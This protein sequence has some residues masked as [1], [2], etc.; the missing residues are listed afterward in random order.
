MRQG[1]ACEEDPV[2]APGA[3]AATNAISDVYAM[4]GTPLMAIAGGPPL[5]GVPSPPLLQ[6]GGFG[7]WGG[8]FP[9][10]EGPKKIAR[11]GGFQ[12]FS[13]SESGPVIPPVCEQM[14][15]RD[16]W[17]ADQHPRPGPRRCWASSG[18]THLVSSGHL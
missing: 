10:S 12:C 11:G 8:L 13:K 9:K 1:H 15:V 7:E 5:T 2:G 18:R 3:V 6:G 16:P 17:V 4:G 14:F